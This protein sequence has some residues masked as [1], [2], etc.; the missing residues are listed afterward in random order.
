MPT[1]LVKPNDTGSDESKKK[2]TIYTTIAPAQEKK[3]RSERKYRDE[4]KEELYRR[5]RLKSCANR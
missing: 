4:R 1:G 3:K 2:V 5:S